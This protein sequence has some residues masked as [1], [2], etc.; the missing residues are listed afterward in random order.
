MHRYPT[1][2]I[3]TRLPSALRGA[4]RANPISHPGAIPGG[5]IYSCVVCGHCA[6][7][8]QQSRGPPSGPHASGPRHTCRV[9]IQVFSVD[10]KFL[11][12]DQAG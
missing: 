11:R 2:R 7:T 1:H 10:L 4:R 12:I 9:R 3:T 6:G 5:Q 8:T